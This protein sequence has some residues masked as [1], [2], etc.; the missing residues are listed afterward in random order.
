MA[1][2]QSPVASARAARLIAR[3]ASSGALATVRKGKDAGRPYVSKVGMAL[4]MDGSPLFLFSTLAAHTQD[5]LADPR[6]SLLVEAPRPENTSNPLQAAR[7]SLVGRLEQISSETDDY[8]R[9]RYLARHPSAV[10]YA[11]FGD[12]SMWRMHVEKVHYVGGFGL[13][14]WA[15]DDDYLYSVPGLIDCEPE[16]LSTPM[17]VAQ[18]VIEI[19]GDGVTVLCPDEMQLRKNFAAPAKDIED[20]HVHFDRLFHD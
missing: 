9:S 17:A 18:S 5:V 8:E 1:D 13:A 4:A 19:D 2:K 6:A 16:L 14:K 7:A 10:Q 20:W 3:A 15:K 11:G 12:F